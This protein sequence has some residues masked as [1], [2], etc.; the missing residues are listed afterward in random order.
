MR[1]PIISDLFTINEPPFTVQTPLNSDLFGYIADPIGVQLPDS[2]DEADWRAFGLKLANIR[3]ATK[4][5]IGDWWI[6]G[7]H[8]Y[9]SR[10]AL[11]NADEWDGPSLQT[12]ANAATVCRAFETSR[13]REVLSF[14]HHAEVAGL[15]T[16][17]ADVLL[18]WAEEP[19]AEFRKP[20]SVR[21]LRHEKRRR[22]LQRG[23]RVLV[24]DSPSVASHN[25]SS[26]VRY[27]R[28]APE[29]PPRRLVSID[30]V[31]PSP[32]IRQGAETVD[33]AIS[34][35]W[36][37]LV[38]LCECDGAQIATRV[39]PKERKQF[40]RDAKEA[41]GQLEALIVALEAGPFAPP[42]ATRPS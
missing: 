36:G 23:A 27:A 8:H 25:A 29:V 31:A 9:G 26:A 21:A 22:A 30:V 2:L 34:A 16:E 5:W 33:P 20:H 3:S 11:L 15:P 13:R 10:K 38:R 19:I 41:R 39:A 32:T 37:C 18:D 7:E 17:E 4:W 12:C 40:L 14:A 6:Y 24:A 42:K 1:A 28:R 35:L